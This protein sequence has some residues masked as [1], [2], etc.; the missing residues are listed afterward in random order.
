MVPAAGSRWNYGFC[1][2]MIK[3][4]KKELSRAHHCV[5]V[6]TTSR[7]SVNTC[8]VVV[9]GE[10]IEGGQQQRRLEEEEGGGQPEG[11]RAGQGDVGPKGISGGRSTVLPLLQ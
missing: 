3:T 6:K 5:R 1:A 2:G 4:D 10:E 7:T 9:V 8:R 11:R